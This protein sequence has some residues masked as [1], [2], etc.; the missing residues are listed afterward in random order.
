MSGPL[1][2]GAS[3]AN[4]YIGNELEL[5]AHARNWKRYWSSVFSRYL[6][7]DVL[8]VGAGLGVNTGSLYN[9]RGVSRWVALEPDQRLF[10]QLR[11]ANLQG[12]EARLGTLDHVGDKELFDAIL[13]IDVLEH[14]AD[15]SAEVRRAAEHLKPG[16]RLLVLAPA[17]PKLYSQF[18][19]AIGHYR[20]YTRR[21]L[22]AV[23]E[24][25]ASLELERLWYLDSCGLLASASNRLLLRQSLPT[26]AQILFWDRFLVPCSRLLDPLLLR[27]CGKSVAAVWRGKASAAPTILPRSEA[28]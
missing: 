14:I 16:G 3:G 21:S 18:D 17:H 10:D 20:R 13:Y 24:R 6:Q 19:S 12:V 2:C 22:K 8:E 9:S 1:D 11:N 25:V 15:D 23:G 7:G 5:F 27:R 26:L 28:R 4:A